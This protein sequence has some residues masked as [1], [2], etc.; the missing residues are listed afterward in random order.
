MEAIVLAGGAGSRL[1]SV[2]KDIPKPMA[3]VNGRPFLEYV[4]NHL[5]KHAVTKVILSVGYKKEVIQDYFG[6]CYKAI[7]IEYAVEE[8]PLGTGG[9]IRRSLLL[10]Q[11]SPVLVI[12]GDTLFR[13]EIGE[14]CTIHREKAADV[15]IAAK[16]LDDLGRYGAVQFNETGRLISF[17]EKTNSKDGHI[18]GGVYVM[19]KDLFVPF[20]LPSAFSFET[21]FLQ[22]R[23]ADLNIHVVPS[24][25]YFID[26]GIPS[27]YEKAQEELG[28]F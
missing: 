12:N 17:V 16:Y 21:D 11:S 22:E 15:T 6:S 19:N 23:V 18:N 4:L 28:I 20:S 1:Q 3:L 13:V 8:T 27:D 5:H 24:D 25:D 14:L 26:I 9:G 7:S 2:L 10:A